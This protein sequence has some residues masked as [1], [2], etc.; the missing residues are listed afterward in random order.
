MQG[1][2]PSAS[3]TAAAP[4]RGGRTRLFSSG[5]TL[6]ELLVV[7]AII[8]VLAGLLLPVLGQAR[9]RA[10]RTR[11]LNNLRQFAL[12][13][14]LYCNDH[15][16]LPPPNDFVPSSVTV[17]RLGQMGRTLGLPVPEGPANVWPRRALQPAWINCPMAVT[18]GHAEGLTLGGGLYT[19]YSYVGGVENS[20]MISMGFATLVR[21]GVVADERNTRRGVLWTDVLNEFHTED[22]RRFEFFHVRHRRSYPDFQFPAGD[23]DGFHRAW[24]D[25][26]VEWIPA[27]HLQLSGRN[28]PDLGLRHLLGNFY[29]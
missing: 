20:R 5:F 25:A 11:C 23:L 28:S 19:G 9:R 13:D 26:S 17:D 15:G 1:L 7:L 16:R 21:P 2:S 8:A 18:S 29:F 24:S 10:V 22:P 14:T 4:R 12:A 3:G 6:V 27:R